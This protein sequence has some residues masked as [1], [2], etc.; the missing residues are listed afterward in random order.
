MF[1]GPSDGAVVAEH[2]RP[3]VLVHLDEAARLADFFEVRAV[4]FYSLGDFDPTDTAENYIVLQ[5]DGDA[6][7]L[8]SNMPPPESGE[9]LLAPLAIYVDL[10][11]PDSFLSLSIR[12]DGTY[13]LS[14]FDGRNDL[15]APHG[16]PEGLNGSLENMLP[17]VLYGMAG[18]DLTLRAATLLH[19]D[20]LDD[21]DVSDIDSQI[22]ICAIDGD[23]LM[24]RRVVRGTQGVGAAYGGS[25]GRDFDR[26]VLT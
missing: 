26:L 15:I 6:I 13:S 17:F 11:K 3:A 9:M 16:A 12:F 20:S 2:R 21:W 23:D 1:M 18:R 5:A 8:S 7:K 24:L 19:V 22:L 10:D 25:G 14:R 4:T